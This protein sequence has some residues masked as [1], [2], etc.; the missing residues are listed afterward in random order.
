MKRNTLLANL[1]FSDLDHKN[2]KHDMAIHFLSQPEILVQVCKSLEIYPLTQNRQSAGIDVRLFSTD[3]IDISVKTEVPIIKGH[4]QYKQT[5]GFIDGIIT[6]E[7]QYTGINNTGWKYE[8][9]LS[10]EEFEIF[11]K[12]TEIGEC[13]FHSKKQTWC[14]LECNAN[15]NGQM[16]RLQPIGKDRMSNDGYQTIYAHKRDGKWTANTNNFTMNDNMRLLSVWTKTNEQPLLTGSEYGKLFIETKYHKT[17]AS[18]IIRQIKLYREYMTTNDNNWCVL[19]F[20]D[21][22]NTEQAELE[23]ANIHWIKMGDKF[24]IWY[25]NQKNSVCKKSKCHL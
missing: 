4:D 23:C 8:T 2:E 20:F 1:G 17:S 13:K 15:I 16:V 12:S 6:F 18:D 25:Q 10:L 5:I 7:L 3:A 22:T 21:L 9:E 14:D 24:E 19:T 11:T